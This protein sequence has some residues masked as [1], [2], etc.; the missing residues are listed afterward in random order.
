[1]N[2]FLM[3]LLSVFVLLLTLTA[4]AQ[5]PAAP[6]LLLPPQDKAVIIRLDGPVDDI[7]LAS[8]KRRTQQALQGGAQLIILEVE[9]YGGQITSALAISKY[10]KSVPVPVAA[11]V[12]DKAYSAGVLITLACNPV[13]MAPQASMGDCE[14]IE[15][16]MGRAQALDPELRAKFSSPILQELANSAQR[17]KVPEVLTRAMVLREVEVWELWNPQAA[18]PETRYVDGPTRQKMLKETL[19]LPDGTL[20]PAWQDRHA[21]PI[22]SKD[23]L[24][25]IGTEQ[26]LAMGL[27]Q[28]SARDQQ[29][30]LTWLNVRGEVQTLTYNWTEHLARWLVLWEIRALFFVA[31]LILAYLEISHPGASIFGLGAVVCLGILV[32]APYFTG[33]ASTWE[34]ITIIVGVLL[35]AADIML[36]GGMGFLTPPGVIL[37]AVG[38]I[39]TFI[40]PDPDGG[41]WPSSPAM[42]GGMQIGACVVVFGSVFSVGVMLGLARYLHM[43]PGFRR[44][45]LQ[46]AAAAMIGPVRDDL[47]NTASDAVF[48][49]AMGLAETDLRP[50]G[51]V[52]FGTHLVD[53]T[54]RGDYIARGTAVDVVE[55]SGLAVVVKPHSQKAN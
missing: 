22:D 33:T 19:P 30:L 43:V 23:T 51:K 26:A 3:S 55:V 37:V 49:G 38:L 18:K 52:R 14:P 46:P 11:W 6:E 12:N 16:V 44:L 40:P 50:A 8:L 5:A 2:R 47:S 28:R 42:W 29:E 31:M 9:T 15:V 39:G 1:M 20:V 34:I 25:T 54:T 27:A 45:Q 21:Q 48:P 17:N 10:I 32:A 36:H 4:H 7:M 13:L 41:S 53:V 35:V 24:L